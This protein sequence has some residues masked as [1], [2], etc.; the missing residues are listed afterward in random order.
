MDVSKDCDKECMLYARTGSGVN[1]K[2]LYARAKE[3]APG[4]YTLLENH[5]WIGC[6][7]DVYTESDRCSKDKSKIFNSILKESRKLINEYLN[8]IRQITNNMKTWELLLK[9]EH[10]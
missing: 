1:M 4:V 7:G 2:M 9:E 3:S 10:E 8:H 6:V 5:T